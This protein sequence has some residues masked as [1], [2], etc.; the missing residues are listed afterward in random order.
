[1]QIQRGSTVRHPISRRRARLH[2]SVEHGDEP[3]EIQ[4]EFRDYMEI[5]CLF[6]GSPLHSP[7]QSNPQSISKPR[8]E[9]GVLYLR[10]QTLVHTRLTHKLPT[11]A[12]YVTTSLTPM[13]T[14]R[15]GVLVSA[16][17]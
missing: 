11:S 1:M 3:R 2:E 8:A 9:V 6:Y 14:V 16:H 15:V 12:A 4:H 13:L 17:S 7:L 5:R 10:E